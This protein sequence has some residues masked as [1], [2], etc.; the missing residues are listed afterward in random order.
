MDESGGLAACKS[1]TMAELSIHPNANAL[2]N[3]GAKQFATLAESAIA[4]RGV[5]NVALA[6]GS[7]P[8]QLYRRLVQPPYLDGLDWLNIHFFFGDERCVPP[9]HPDSNYGM[10]SETLLA[11]IPL[12]ETNI[13]RIPGEL[14]PTQAAEAYAAELQT[15]FGGLLPEFDLVLLGLGDD[16]HTASLFPGARALNE[17]E[18]WVTAVD[19][20][21]PP[22][23]LLP[24]ITLTLPVLNA[25]RSVLFLVSGAAKAQVLA[26]VLEN[27]PDDPL[28]AR[29]VKP[30]NGSLLFLADEE[31]AQF[32]HSRE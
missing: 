13:H 14:P 8:R 31:A 19:H 4:L 25:A 11:H 5:F 9:D 2:S 17:T 6:G 1:K 12:P 16:G 27:K 20:T 7:T 21:T 29:Q 23:P 28:P 26:R 32:V 24:R 30:V 3:A 10:A 15:A 22:P 18:R